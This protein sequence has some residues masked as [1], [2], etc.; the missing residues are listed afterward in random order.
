MF[1]QRGEY[2][3]RSIDVTSGRDTNKGKQLAF[4]Q[5]SIIMGLSTPGGQTN[6]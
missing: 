3:T 4:Y 2:V 1:T 6:G 5:I